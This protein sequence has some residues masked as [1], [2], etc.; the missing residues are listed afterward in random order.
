MH[1][2]I[3]Y[4]R[5]PECRRLSPWIEVAVHHRSN[6]EV[7]QKIAYNQLRSPLAAA[8]PVC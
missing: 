7:Q 2:I 8:V 5:T 1:N 6:E 3:I 4:L